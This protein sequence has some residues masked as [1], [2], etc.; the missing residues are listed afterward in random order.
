MRHGTRRGMQSDQDFSVRNLCQNSY[1][2]RC[3]VHFAYVALFFK[4]NSFYPGQFQGLTSLPPGLFFN[5]ATWSH[6]C[7]LFKYGQRSKI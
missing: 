4:L 3:K 6:R 7:R 5:V 2:Q 1:S